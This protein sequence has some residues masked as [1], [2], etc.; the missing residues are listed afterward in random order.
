MIGGGR[1]SFL[2]TARKMRAEWDRE[3]NERKEPAW[4]GKK[5]RTKWSV[6]QIQLPFFRQRGGGKRWTRAEKKI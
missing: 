4:R 6:P 1:M 2:G 5:R 3:K